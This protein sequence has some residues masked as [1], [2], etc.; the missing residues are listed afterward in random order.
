MRVVLV[1][2]L[3]LI[4]LLA[5]ATFIQSERRS[6]AGRH[7]FPPQGAFLEID[8]H[9]IHY[10]DRGIADAA[11]IVLLHGASGNARD[12]TFD[13]MGRLV[14]HYRVIA[15]DRPGLGHSPALATKGVSV[16]DQ[17]GILSK[18]AAQLG[19]QEPV[20]VGHSFGGAVAMAW[21]VHHPDQISA[22]V[23][24]AGATYPWEGK[25]DAFHGRLAHPFFGP[26]FAR[27]VSAWTNDEYV[28]N[29][30]NGAFEPQSAPSTYGASVGLPLILSP[31]SLIANAQ[32]RHD[33]REELRALAPRYRSL[34]LPIE[35]IHGDVDK[36]VGLSVHSTRM[37]EDI[38]K[39]NL[40]VLSGVGHMP[41][42]AE[43]DAAVAAIQRAV[44]RAGLH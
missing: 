32:Q 38:A 6:A 37:V 31:G 11:T 25:L 23:S 26:V 15:F 3:I 36:I 28:A 7:K 2:A 17:A 8:G 29:A 21:A 19:A 43:P 22:V 13:L 14:G 41:H 16:T 9:Q 5:I 33:L 12:F 42:H 30:V 34:E 1:A 18:A 4:G 44:T 10:I 40:V 35:I 39:A 20:V 27:L 24:F